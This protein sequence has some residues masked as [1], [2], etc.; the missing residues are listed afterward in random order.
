MGHKRIRNSAGFTLIELIV[1]IAIMGIILILALPQVS[2]I[3]EANKDRKF[4]VYQSSIARG[5]K[6]YI[7]SNAKDLFGNNNSGCITLKY[8]DLKNRSLVKDF[9]VADIKCNKDEETY[10]EVRKVNKNYKY[11]VSIVCRENEDIVYE[12]RI[13]DTFACEN[14][15]D[16]EAPL[17]TITPEKYNW[18]QSKNIKVKIKVEDPSG[19]NRNIGIKYY[20]TDSSGKKVGKTY[21]YN[22]KNKKG[23]SK[24]SYQIPEKN[25]P[26]ASGQYKL[27]VEPWSSG[28]TNGIQD[29]LGNVSLLSKEAGLYQIDNVKPTC[30]TAEGEKTNWTNQNFIIKQ[31][32]KDDASGCVKNPYPK[33]FTTTTKTY[34]FTIKDKAGNSN[35]CKVDV[36]LDKTAPTCTSSGGSNNWSTKPVT[37]TGTCSDSNSG[38]KGNVT[39]T[40]SNNGQWTNQSPGTVYDK[41]GNSKA[42]PANQTI[43]IAEKPNK[44]TINNPTGGNWVNY[45]FALTVSTTTTADVIGSWQYSYNNKNWTTY[46]N[47]AKKSTFTTTQFTKERNQPVYIRV[48]NIANVCSESASTNIR[49]D[50][51]KPTLGYD[52]INDTTGA[53]YTPGTWSRNGVYRYLYP[54]DNASGIREVQTSDGNG[55]W[56]EPNLD[57][58]WVNYEMNH[59]YKHRVVDNAGNYSDV[60]SLHYML[61][62][63]APTCGTVVGA[64]TNWT[65]TEDRYITQNCNDSGSGC[66]AVNKT[67][68]TDT[69]D[70]RIT[71]QDK[72]GNTN[73][74]T[75][76]VY[77]DKTAPIV[78][79]FDYEYLSGYAICNN[80]FT[81]IDSPSYSF[82]VRVYNARTHDVSTNGVQSGIDHYEIVL[83]P[84][85]HAVDYSGK[86][87]YI[88]CGEENC[89]SSPYRFKRV[90]VSTVQSIG[91]GYYTFPSTVATA[92][93]DNGYTGNTN[94]ICADW[95]INIRAYDKAGNSRQMVHSWGTGSTCQKLYNNSQG[96]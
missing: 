22:Y 69:Q 44:P 62:W 84:T 26:T 49:I 70:A 12:D 90:T 76:H 43:K 35:T 89:L 34:T 86:A 51:T 3:L 29:A 32:C 79:S 60:V 59:T 42:C 39:K 16:T 11:A 2:K 63:T 48:C 36:Y 45:N 65:N 21:Q 53:K 52:L 1:V 38:C 75:V 58:Y 31:E 71:I 10:V 73:T 91:D 46:A 64:S 92:R 82:D 6:L 81:Y 23:T 56:H 40:Y 50:K 37:I 8:S 78:D 47:S 72:V 83:A 41:A 17:V 15:P 55:W 33:E 87:H 66:T 67:Y 93:I 27:V 7:D 5:A 4:Q 20:W 77:I 88:L 30:G 74:C 18:T 9:A 96:Y 57:K 80:G 85:Y 54:K 95:C 14:K 61:D 13:D 94:R 19:L 28:T 68:T 24:V 25:V